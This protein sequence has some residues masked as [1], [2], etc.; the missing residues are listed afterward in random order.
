M[1]FHRLLVALLVAP[2]LLAGCGKSPFV[3]GWR[4]KEDSLNTELLIR[5]DGSGKEAY[6]SLPGLSPENMKKGTLPERVK[7]SDDFTWRTK[8]DT[9]VVTMA[10]GDPGP[11]YVLMLRPD[12]TLVR[13]SYNVKDSPEQEFTSFPDVYDK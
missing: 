5:K 9:A 7:K 10:A 3:G 12:G 4:Q 6:M 2:C 1:H 11:D 13:K 8:G